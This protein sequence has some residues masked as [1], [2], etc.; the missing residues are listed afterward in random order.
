MPTS[1]SL[2]PSIREPLA[3]QLRQINLTEE[4][5]VKLIEA[6][7]SSVTSDTSFVSTTV[8]DINN[9]THS[10]SIPTSSYLYKEIKRISNNID[11]LAGIAS[12]GASI[13]D[14]SENP[15]RIIVSSL[16]RS[17]PGNLDAITKNEFARI[18]IT[19][20]IYDL[21]YPCPKIEFSLPQEFNT[22]RCAVKKL[23]FNSTA[24]L[25]NFN[26]KV[27]IVTVRQYCER[28]GIEYTEHDDVYDVDVKHDNWYGS[29]S[30]L[31]ITQETNNTVTCLLDKLTYNDIRTIKN[32]R[33]LQVGDMLCDK[34]G[35]GLFKINSINDVNVSVNLS[36]VTG[37]NNLGSGIRTLWY[38]YDAEKIST[39]AVPINGSERSLVFIAPINPITNATDGYTGAF[40]IDTSSLY[41]LNGNSAQVSFDSWFN[42][43]VTNIGQYLKSMAEDSTIPLSDG[44]IP[45][46]PVLDGASFN[47]VQINKHI[48]D[49]SDVDR[50]KQ[51]ATEKEQVFAKISTL[52]KKIA[53]TNN[54]IN[55]G[56]YRSTNDRNDDQNLL[57]TLIN[58]KEQQTAIYASLVK[59]ITSK[60]NTSESASYE[61][62]Y[63][64][65]GFWPVQQPIESLNTRDQHIIH[66][67]IE[68]RYLNSRESVSNSDAIRY[69][70]N[71][72]YVA[73]LISS[74]NELPS[75][76]LKRIRNN[77][78]TYSWSENNPTSDDVISINQ[79]DI[80]IKPN[81]S[82]EI[83]VK[84]CSEAGFPQTML[85][86]EWSDILRIDFPA[87]L[88]REQ[89][90][91]QTVADNKEDAK[92]LEV[93]Q[94]LSEKGIL[95]HVQLSFTE[96][97]RYFAHN[98]HNIASGFFSPEQANI[99]LYEYLQ[100]LTGKIDTI[101][102]LL[103]DD[104]NRVSVDIVDESGASYNV[105]KNGTT[106][107]FAGYYLDN[108]ATPGQIVTKKF[109][110]RI[111]NKTNQ[112]ILLHSRYPGKMDG[113]LTDDLAITGDAY[114]NADLYKNV[115]FVFG[116]S[117]AEN[118]FLSQIVYSKNKDIT[119]NVLVKNSIPDSYND[120][121]KL[122]F[123]VAT[124]DDYEFV[125]CDADGTMHYGKFAADSDFS[126]FVGIAKQYY[127]DNETDST[128]DKNK[129][130]NETLR[131]AT[132]I[133][134][135]ENIQADWLPDY[136]ELVE[137]GEQH[138]APSFNKNDKYLIGL[139]SCGARLFVEPS[140]RDLIQVNGSSADAYMELNG[141]LDN[142]IY[143]PITFQYRMQDASGRYGVKDITA[144]LSESTN[145]RYAK[146]INIELYINRKVVEYDL[147]VYSELRETTTSTS[148]LST[149]QQTQIEN[150]ID[151]NDDVTPSFS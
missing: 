26:E 8:T 133:L 127:I 88:L 96:N 140:S 2:N 18:D 112:T 28:N 124:A 148:S 106:T 33:T 42:N 7:S 150:A 53:T 107:L 105:A 69:V 78:G 76:T 85:E 74:W 86:S 61:P 48:T 114:T 29:F 38:Q 77:D 31:S 34:D 117:E 135:Q 82:V 116:N 87:D 84:A 4:N 32:T 143:I 47:V 89:S 125:T 118:Q 46:K 94:L 60:T 40:K 19:S 108:V 136:S 80:P 3:E 111:R 90:I 16:L 99:S 138:I 62:K 122:G 13:I 101:N 130:A 43:T 139:N 93:E 10:I 51:L 56:R 126:K 147:I 1:T 123:T 36:L 58:E 91:A 49:T 79:C 103:S 73:G 50:I 15:R 109:Y 14:G 149:L 121:N 97:N 120:F 146:K 27:D 25:S 41:I 52:N 132:N 98:A 71:D 9:V 137:L 44:I 6:I 35:I 115:P 100:T 134:N 141:G 20:A 65:R 104:I 67:R 11:T 64:I 63:R 145:T 151:Y 57:Q 59:D 102:A 30:I 5:L 144:Q 68:Y 39:I 83:R 95:K 54:R 45:D 81:E 24:D 110:L 17:L 131:Y 128:S 12:G 119:G 72:Q 22:N 23:R 21:M 70:E 75:S 113:F 129:F 37:V 92:K 142:A 66:Y 55:T